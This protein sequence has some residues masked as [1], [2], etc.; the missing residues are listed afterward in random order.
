M[1]NG[2]SLSGKTYLAKKIEKKFPRTF[3]RIDS[4]T[5]HDFLNREYPLFDDDKTVIGQSFD[6]RQKA[7]KAVQK[8]FMESVV[9]EGC[10]VI[11]DSCNSTYEKR[12]KIL[13]N[14]R[15]VAP[16]AVTI[17][18]HIDISE[19][20]LL[21]RLKRHDREKV[22]NGETPA[23]V[24]LYTQIQKKQFKKPKKGESDYLIN[25]KGGEE[26]KVF[27]QLEKILKVGEQPKKSN[28]SSKKKQTL[29]ALLV[30]QHLYETFCAH[31]STVDLLR[32]YKS[33]L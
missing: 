27:A 20:K 5:I 22:K 8:A 25:F 21:K 26:S 15:K 28:F 33:G 24:D 3:V 12:Q 10:S 18:I 32:E 13:N 17:I 11:L 4:T 9:G 2:F 30:F 31:P 7:T 16:K 29:L 14:I 6:L 19:E 23:W 1:M